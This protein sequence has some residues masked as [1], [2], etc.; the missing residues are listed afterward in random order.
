MSPR[1]GA[2]DELTRVLALVPWI[3]AH[4]GSTKP[5]I[6]QRF[7]VSVQQLEADLWLLMMVGVPPYSPGDYIDVDP[8]AET[9]EIRLA[10]YFTRP[11]R[12]SPAEGLALLAAGRALLA[13]PG[14]DASGPL[15]T[16]LDR[17]AHALEGVDVVVD[18]GEPRFLG[19]VRAAAL[20]GR[21]IE[22]E[23]FAAG[24]DEVTTRTI[25]PGPPFFAMGQWYTD[26]YCHER[27]ENRMFRL[28]RIRRIRE[29]GTSFVPTFDGA[30]APPAVFTATA[31]DTKVTVLFPPGAAWV[32]ESTPVDSVEELPTGG[33]RVVL[34]VGATA[35]LERLLLQVGPEARIEDPP[36]YRDLAAVAA[37]R[38]LARYS[39]ATRPPSRAGP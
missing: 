31:T 25:D 13:V 5:E 16:A 3:I 4:P 37:H 38:V 39:G 7:G 8:E 11:L 10:D 6:A 1:Q 36:E 14:S 2:E 18:F 21:S 15:A 32:A 20:G 19:E 34:S 26:A 23:Y 27:D 33:Q 12:L 17:L 28:D 35:W 22:I 29:T 9:V 30:D 24:R